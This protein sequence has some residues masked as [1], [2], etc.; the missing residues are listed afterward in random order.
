MF[1][2]NIFHYTIMIIIYL[3]NKM[4]EVF[5]KKK[6]TKQQLSC[7]SEWILLER[8]ILFFFIITD[9][10]QYDLLAKLAQRSGSMILCMYTWYTT[11][12]YIDLDWTQWSTTI[13]AYK[14][15]NPRNVI[16]SNEVINIIKFSISTL[17]PLKY[18]LQSSRNKTLGL[19]V[20]K[21]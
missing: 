19:Y 3:G 12:C 5:K 15:R 16:V 9:L 14:H 1:A 2:Q 8:T 20:R 18:N 10:L 11:Q 21:K 17:S 6:K 7:A 4:M 13:R